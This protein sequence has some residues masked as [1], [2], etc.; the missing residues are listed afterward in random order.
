MVLFER[1]DD[2]FLKK[3]KTKSGIAPYKRYRF[4][5]KTS[6]ELLEG[7]LYLAAL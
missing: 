4:A 6:N 3:Q 1:R 2:S 5:S 7:K